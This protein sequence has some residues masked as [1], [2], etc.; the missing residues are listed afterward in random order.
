MKIETKHNF[1]KDGKMVQPEI[2]KERIK[3]IDD[4]YEKLRFG[5]EP[6]PNLGER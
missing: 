3:Q 4:R 2:S 5:V 1:D 6:K